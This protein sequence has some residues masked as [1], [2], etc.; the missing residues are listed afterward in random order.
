MKF[1]YVTYFSNK[2][3]TLY[4]VKSEPFK[5]SVL[6]I[7]GG[8]FI[9]L[10][11][12]FSF[13]FPIMI[14]GIVACISLTLMGIIAGFMSLLEPLRDKYVEKEKA[15]TKVKR[16]APLV[17]INVNVPSLKKEAPLSD[18]LTDSDL[19][20][21]SPT[22][23]VNKYSILNNIQNANQS[24]YKI[25]AEL[26]DAML[27]KKD[28][29]RLVMSL[30]VLH[31]VTEEYPQDKLI[32]ITNTLFKAYCFRHPFNLPSQKI[33]NSVLECTEHE[34][35]LS[36]MET[37]NLSGDS[38]DAL[39]TLFRSLWAKQPNIPPDI[40]LHEWS[41]I[42]DV[43]ASNFFDVINEILLLKWLPSGI[44][45]KIPKSA[46]YSLEKDTLSEYVNRL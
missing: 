3:G 22:V 5:Q 9:L 39:D 30:L 27:L 13:N 19:A 33:F 1:D 32:L 20:L 21:A 24:V 6:P 11:T 26:Y 4:L 44:F 8:A 43:T 29:S 7:I 35:I 40:H 45:K 42:P 15:D 12:F 38:Y 10:L 36:F 31:G 25:L 34:D 18:N 2:G 46:L 16:S 37:I 28:I 23:F 14:F 17:A 41:D